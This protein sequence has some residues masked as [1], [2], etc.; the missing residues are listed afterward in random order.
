M[1]HLIS[2]TKSDGTKQLFEESKLVSSL[3]RVGAPDDV[4]ES[5]ID[6]VEADMKDGMTTS[7]IYAHAFALLKKHSVHTA[8]KYSIRH[9]L[10]ELGPDGFPFERFVAR[11]FQAWG[12]EAVTDQQVMGTCISHE[13]DV[14]AWKDDQLAMV[15]AKF[16]N[17]LILKSDVKVVLYIK[18]RFDDIQP[19]FFDYGGV[20]RQLS[21]RWLFTNTKFTEQAIKYGECNN[22]RLVGWNYPVT[23]N[24][25]QIIEQYKLHPITCIS[26]LSHQHKMELI[27]KGVLTC[28]DLMVKPNELI[29]VGIKDSVEVE[30]IIAEAQLV[31]ESTDH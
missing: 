4:I 24:L 29:D 13:V 9:A 7:Q 15:E 11:I 30:K 27:G 12:Y 14:V 10:A 16:H 19:N 18:S 2:I 26:S 28:T 23:G 22:L 6:R 5:V 8:I 21:Q 1:N 3:K 31:L 25:H 17:E 20:K